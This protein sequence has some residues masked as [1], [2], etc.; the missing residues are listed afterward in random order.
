[1]SKISSM[2]QRSQISVAK[3]IAQMTSQV[4][5]Q[6]HDSLNCSSFYFLVSHFFLN[7]QRDFIK[8]E[9]LLQR[10]YLPA[11]TSS[12]SPE[13]YSL[14]TMASIHSIAIAI[15]QRTNYHRAESKSSG[16]YPR[17][18]AVSI[19]FLLEVRRGVTNTKK[20]NILLILS[21][22]LLFLEEFQR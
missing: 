5:F 1:M 6:A 4:L 18:E 7:S 11:I 22:L 9:C 2:P 10:G 3:C 14:V 12:V 19:T 8:I 15:L 13:K 17:I 20:K 21:G 16:G